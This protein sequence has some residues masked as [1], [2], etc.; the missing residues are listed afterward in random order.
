MKNIA[1]ILETIRSH[2][3]VRNLLAADSAVETPEQAAEA[4]AKAA[5][6]LGYKL[7]G[8]EILAYIGEAESGLRRKADETVGAI[9]S[10]REEDLAQA[11]G[12]GYHPECYDTYK[13]H[14]NC[15]W[16]D[17]CDVIHEQY[18]DYKCKS[19]WYCWKTVAIKD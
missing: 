4:Y 7:T 18:K 15:W 1:E 17:G 16:T 12:G 19:S 10:L 13:D 9:Q 6:K 3:D 14:E 8:E 5:E 2:S 11:A